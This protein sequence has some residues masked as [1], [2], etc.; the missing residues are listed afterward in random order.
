[1]MLAHSILA[2][3]DPPTVTVPEVLYWF[4]YAGIQ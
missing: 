4:R 2:V 1:M 3:N